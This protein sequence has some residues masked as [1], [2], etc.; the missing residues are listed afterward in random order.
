MARRTFFSF[1]YQRDLWRLNQIRNIP[2]ITGC[3]AAGFQDASL[4]EVAK[5]KG[6]AAIKKLIDDGLK[7][8]SVTVVCIGAKTAGR[9]YINYEIEQSIKRG[10]GIVGIQIHH[11]KDKDGHPDDVGGIPAKL[12]NNGYK[13]YKYMD[14]KKLA[15]RVEEAAGK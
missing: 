8:T 13:V 6:D 1:H 3:S 10:N 12:K 4:W 7:N 9:K 5:E 15:Q 2:N 11:L 14:H